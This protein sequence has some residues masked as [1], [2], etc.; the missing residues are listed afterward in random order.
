M[1]PLPFIDDN[2]EKKLPRGNNLIMNPFFKGKKKK[3]KKG[4]KKKKWLFEN[5]I[6]IIL[7]LF[8]IIK[9]K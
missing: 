8:F 7:I 3:K 9:F 6:I 4:K 5:Y 2:I 1:T